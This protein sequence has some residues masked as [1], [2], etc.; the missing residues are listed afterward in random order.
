MG[1]CQN[2]GPFLGTLNIRCRIIIRTQTGTR[3]FT[4]NQMNKSSLITRK[5]MACIGLSSNSLGILQAAEIRPCDLSLATGKN[6]TVASVGHCKTREHSRIVFRFKCFWP[7][8]HRGSLEVA[9]TMWP[10]QTAHSSSGWCRH[11]PGRL[12]Q[13]PRWPDIGV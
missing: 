6:A 3:I 4:T 5:S 7:A 1:S 13:R 8:S 11:T 9:G 2:Y 12:L 10:A